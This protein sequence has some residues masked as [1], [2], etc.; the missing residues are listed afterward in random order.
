MGDE[1][2]MKEVK[3][4]LKS[5]TFWFGILTLLGAVITYLVELP[6]GVTVG[7]AAVGIINILLRFLTNQPIGK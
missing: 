4:F 6:V 1:I 2:T 3:S 7:T 5:K